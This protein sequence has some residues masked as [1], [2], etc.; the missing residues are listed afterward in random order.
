MAAETLHSP[1]EA[2]DHIHNL[3]EFLEGKHFDE[4]FSTTHEKALENPYATL[5]LN[6][7]CFDG[8][9]PQTKGTITYIEKFRFLSDANG[10]NTVYHDNFAL[11]FENG[12]FLRARGSFDRIRRDSWSKP[13][14]YT[15]ELL[16]V[17]GL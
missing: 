3:N 7:D 4:I 6:H 17:L 15:Q 10:V 5:S 12:I 2:P 9:D 16:D 13:E 11:D 14:S 8:L 1:E